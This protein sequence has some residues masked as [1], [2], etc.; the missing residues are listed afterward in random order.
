MDYLD[1]LV[2]G[3]FWTSPNGFTAQ[4]RP[5][6]SK[7]SQLDRSGGTKKRVELQAPRSMD[8]GPH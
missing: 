2:T 7:V 8:E 6:F 5:M 4:V 1:N 3:C